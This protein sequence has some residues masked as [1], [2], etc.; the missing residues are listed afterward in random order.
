MKKEIKIG[1]RIIGPGHP[2]YIIAEMSANHAG[3]INR[4]IEIIH[5]AKKAG[6]DCIK[7][8][9]YT[10]DTLTIDCH[11][12]YFNVKNGTW[13]GE[14][15]YSLYGKAYT[16]WE[17]QAQLQ[18]EAIKVGIDFL[19]TPFDTTSVDFLEKLN[20]DFYK[21]ASFEMIDLPLVRYIAK[22]GKP[23]IM[24]TGMA[25]E[26]EIKEAIRAIDETG[27][28]QLV[29]L[30]CSSAY[31]AKTEEMNLSTI[32]DMQEKY[33]IPVGLSDHS[34]G[35]MSA[36]TAVTLGANVIEKHFCISR[37]IENP[38]ASF[39]MNPQEFAEMVYQIRET[40]AALGTP[41][42]GVAPQEEASV[43]FRRSIFAVAD[44]DKGEKFCD[45]NVRIIRPGYGM[46]PKYWDDLLTMRAS[47][48]MK[49]GTPVQFSDVEQGGVLFLTNNHNTDELYQALCS[50]GEKIY[51]FENKLTLDLIKEINPEFVISFNYRY[52]ISGEIIDYMK[53]RI[54]N[55]HT[56]YLPFNKGSAPNFFSFYDD[57]PKGVTIHKMTAGLDAGPVLFQQQV[58]FDE[59]TETFASSYQKL[60]QTIT[61][62][63]LQHWDELKNNTAVPI[64]KNERG[65][66]HRA[67]E[68]V[69]LREK[70]PFTW[71]D[72]ISDVMNKMKKF[73]FFRVD[74]NEEIGTGHLMRCLTI[75]AYMQTHKKIT[76]VF[77]L[78]D[79]RSASIL[80]PY[81]SKVINLN[82]DYL[83]K[84]EEILK[85]NDLLK[86][87]TPVCVIVDSYQVD[88]EYFEALHHLITKRSDVTTL[89][90]MD[91]INVPNYQVDGYINYNIYA[92]TLPYDRKETSLLGAAYIPLR[93]EYENIKPRINKEVKHVMITSGGADKYA[94]CNSIAEMLAPKYSDIVFHV[95]SG[96]FNTHRSELLTLELKYSN[97]IVEQSVRDMQKL[98]VL[99]DV[100]IASSGSTMYELSAAGVPTITYYFVDNQKMIATAYEQATGIVNA[101]DYSVEP[102]Q[103]LDRMDDDFSKLV[104]DLEMRENISSNMQK[105]TDGKGVMRIAEALLK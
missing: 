40:E 39:S 31:P 99:C 36:V 90:Y 28:D 62:L 26:E 19:S 50:R 71:N 1:N 41:T 96:P 22:T 53:G 47:H 27:N 16:P 11:N 12:E 23:I 66:Y 98:Q 103:V 7:I 38:D 70:Y 4:A 85:W 32:R 35:H 68:L 75:A 48:A 37:D 55:L 91:D 43:V 97:I 46:K 84:K 30:K 72:T 33:Q 56:S 74:A 10:P 34:M 21:I 45:Q 65:T 69:E 95:V 61:A 24:S 59:T 81:Q 49:R 29:I 80:Q 104:C 15:L 18:E 3:D 102:Q 8:Q 57:T 54:I 105:I 86:Q 79:L 63:C 64:C 25:T 6:A 77:I 100:A 44:I 52:L 94:V 76:P 73:I 93:P 5:A 14:N 67:R 101:G 89:F 58:E 9:T 60:I 2:A 13:E 92:A 87:Y 51:R 20:L 78:S 83:N 42:Y 17:W 88:K 82:V